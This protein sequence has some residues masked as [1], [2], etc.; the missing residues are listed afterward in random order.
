[1]RTVIWIFQ[2]QTY[3]NWSFYVATFV[4]KIFFA[5][6]FENVGQNQF[7]NYL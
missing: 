3:E 6:L 2:Q 1:M 4:F 7:V 5:D